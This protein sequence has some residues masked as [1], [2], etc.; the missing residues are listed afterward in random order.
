MKNN[1][2]HII[3]GIMKTTFLFVLCAL[4]SGAAVFGQNAKL[5]TAITQMGYYQEDTSDVKP[6]IKAKESI[7][8]AAAHEKTS[9]NP[10]T[11]RYKGQIYWY[12]ASQKK[13]PTAGEGALETAYDAFNKVIDMEKDEKK[14]KQTKDAMGLMAGLHGDLYNKGYE[15]FQAKDFDQGY[16]YFSKAKSIDDMLGR[17]EVAVLY[18]TAACAESAGMDGEAATMYA[19]L[20]ELDFDEPRI[21]LALAGLM[22]KSGDEKGAEDVMAKGLARYPDSKALL[23]DQVNSLLQDGGD[24]EATKA[25]IQ[26]AIKLD[27]ENASLRFALGTLFE[28]TGDM[29]GAAGA[30]QEAIDMNP[31]DFNAQYNMGAL[32]YNQAASKITAMNEVPADDM[33]KYDALKDESD[34]LMGKALPFFEKALSLNSEDPGVNQALKEIYARLGMMDKLSE[35]KAK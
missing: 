34:A 35:L 15:Y 12:L 31:E 25:K 16:Q 1:L 32:F 9:A 8:L 29:D 33:A 27:P 26:E 21:Y 24:L 3:S 6:L 28:K 22:R 5:Q 14:K 4:V 18:A 20:I 23:F 2:Q 7:D 17:E 13:D 19:R 10:K 30:Y 11:F